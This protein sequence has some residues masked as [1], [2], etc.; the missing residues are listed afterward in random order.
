[1]ANRRASWGIVGLVLTLAT[2]PSLQF[3]DTSLDPVMLGV[4]SFALVANPAAVVLFYLGVSARSTLTPWRLLDLPE[5]WGELCDVA[6]HCALR[7]ALA[8]ADTSGRRRY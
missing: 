4:P 6:R 3:S 2:V 8:P 5:L 1:M 7:L